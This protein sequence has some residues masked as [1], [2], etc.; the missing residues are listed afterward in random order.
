MTLARLVEK[1]EQALR[2]ISLG[3]Q[4]SMTSKEDLGR[5]A[6]DYFDG[7]RLMLV[8]ATMEEK[9]L[10]FATLREANRLRLPEFR[11][12]QGRRCHSNEDGSDWKLSAWSNA[13]LGEL[14]ELA[15]IIKKIERG[16]FDQ[17]AVQQDLADELADVVTYLDILAYRCNVDLG[18]ATINKFN[19]VS[20]RVKSSVRIA[21]DGNGV[22]KE[23]SR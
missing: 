6:R 4:N 3:S 11:D 2:M 21:V 14:G 8:L 16:D 12:K 19:R 20:E 7:E 23:S 22:T 10:T 18:S 15:N 9:G 13:V 1:A 17:T 5:A